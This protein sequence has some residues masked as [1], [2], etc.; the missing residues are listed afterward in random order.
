MPPASPLRRRFRC[1]Y[2]SHRSPIRHFLPLPPLRYADKICCLMPLRRYDAD[3]AY[4][5]DDTPIIFIR[6]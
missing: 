2:T 6:A 4:A 5:A 1:Y 3:A